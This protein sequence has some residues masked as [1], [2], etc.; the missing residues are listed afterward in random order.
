MESA[1]I[2]STLQPTVVLHINEENGGK[3]ERKRKNK[4]ADEIKL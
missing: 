4:K 3:G 2:V 1:N